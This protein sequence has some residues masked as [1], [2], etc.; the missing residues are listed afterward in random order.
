MTTAFAHHSGLRRPGA[1][2]LQC[3]AVVPLQQLVPAL[4]AVGE[5]AVHLEHAGVAGSEGGR[6][7]LQHAAAERSAVHALA[8]VQPLRH[9]CPVQR[10]AKVAGAEG[11][12]SEHQLHE[13][14]FF[15][16]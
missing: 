2:H 11:I 14:D 7:A 9:Y 3:Q 12:F 5:G 1:A 4:G 8:K 16:T 6:Q 15:H 13:F 10:P